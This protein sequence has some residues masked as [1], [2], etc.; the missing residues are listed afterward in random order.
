M[1]MMKLLLCSVYIIGSLGLVLFIHIG[2][3]GLLYA[4]FSANITKIP[5]GSSPVGLA[6][7]PH[8][9]NIYVADANSNSNS[10]LVLD[11][12]TNK[13]VN[14]TVIP[15]IPSYMVSDGIAIH[16]LG[17]DNLTQIRN[18]KVFASIDLAHYNRAPPTCI[19]YNPVKNYLYA[20]DPQS[21]GIAVIGI[22]SWDAQY[23][24]VTNITGITNPRGI[25]FNPVD[26]NMYA[27]SSGY[28]SASL[29][30]IDST[31]NR[32]E[33]I[34]DFGSDSSFV[35]ANGD[36]LIYNPVNN[37]IYALVGERTL[38]VVDP[39]TG[40]ITNNIL[41]PRGTDNLAFNPK[42]GNVYI[43]GAGF[44]EDDKFVSVIDSIT[45]SIVKN[46]KVTREPFWTSLADMEYN[47]TNG[48][49]YVSEPFGDSV[50]VINEE[51]PR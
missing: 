42:N 27:I 19:A 41:V 6:Y 29:F 18:G 43:L 36:M 37:K 26:G 50:Y 17:N 16:I 1:I 23:T 9:G 24:W 13:M 48:N 25:T 49:M 32:I 21:D 20:C 44:L 30:R 31:T 11:S 14:K 5:A 35:M 39:K 10:T 47:P 3:I 2:D 40:N 45:N 46:I 22:N 34:T 8:D 28:P 12:D 7:N 38:S 15:D 33:K 51:N 4:S